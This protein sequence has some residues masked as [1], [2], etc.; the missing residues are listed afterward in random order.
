MRKLIKPGGYL[1]TLVFPI[2][3]YDEYGP[4]FYVQPEHYVEVLGERVEGSDDPEGWIKVVDKV[5]AKSLNDEHVGREKLV[6]WKRV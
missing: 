2:R 5:P 1:I 4:P 3:P 6:I